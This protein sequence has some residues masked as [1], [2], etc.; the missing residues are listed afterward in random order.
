MD[1]LQALV[2]KALPL[3][4]S[5]RKRQ[6]DELSTDP[7]VSRAETPQVTKNSSSH[8]NQVNLQSFEGI[9]IK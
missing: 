6:I 7:V 2:P 9:I 4:L 1:V 8:T 5:N 3:S